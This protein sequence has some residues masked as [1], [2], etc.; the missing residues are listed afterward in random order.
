M[1]RGITRIVLVVGVVLMLFGVSAV[2]VMADD[3]IPTEPLPPMDEP[4][5]RVAFWLTEMPKLVYVNGEEF[6]LQFTAVPLTASVQ[7]WDVDIST[8][9]TYGSQFED[10]DG[11]DPGRQAT[12]RTILLNHGIIPDTRNPT[13]TLQQIWRE[14]S[15]SERSALINEL[16]Q[17]GFRYEPWESAL[18]MLRN[19]WLETGLCDGMIGLVSGPGGSM[20]L[21]HPCLAPWRSLERLVEHGP[22]G[23]YEFTWA[24]TETL[25]IAI[26]YADQGYPVELFVVNRGPVM[27]EDRD[28]I[29]EIIDMAR[30]HGIRVNVVPMGNEPGDHMRF[31]YLKPLRELAEGTGGSTYYRPNLDNIYDFSMLPGLAREIMRDFYGRMGQVDHGTLVAPRASL[32]L[33]PSEYVQ[34][35]SP[36]TR[37]DFENLRV[38]EPQTVD[39]HLQVTTNV[40]ETL[41][42]VFQGTPDRADGQSSYFEWFDAT[43]SI[44][45]I[46]LPQRVISVTTGTQAAGPSPTPTVTPSPPSSPMPTQP[47]PPT[48]TATPMPTA[49][50]TAV[51]TATPSPTATASPTTTPVRRRRG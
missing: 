8:Y 35:V 28:R 38:G 14:L 19:F 4:G 43:G 7:V 29:A 26:Q 25:Q 50:A 21:H 12:V 11:L 27:D 36:E 49:T 6:T 42:P 37:I 46:P 13:E 3:G 5:P 16:R 24:L 47:P 40:T 32:V 18:D 44:H 45:R 2:M 9:M 15:E 34:I 31:P 10:G 41:L 1:K 33:A 48:E 17:L 20:L 30:A 39:I 22:T 23:W 51:P